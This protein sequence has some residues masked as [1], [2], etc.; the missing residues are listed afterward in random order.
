MEGGVSE[1]AWGLQR[2]AL[3][4]RL[5]MRELGCVAG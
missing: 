5:Y 3:V 1:V 4:K 2:P